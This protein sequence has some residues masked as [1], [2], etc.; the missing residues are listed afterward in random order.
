MS[1][2][3]NG[4]IAAVFVEMADLTHIVGGDEHRIR[5]FRRAARV[6]E[7]LPQDVETAIKYGTFEK[8]AGIG[9]GTVRRCKQI[10]KSG[11]CD[12][13]RELR[14]ILPA[15]LRDLLEV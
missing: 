6:I 3:E 8:T 10:L 4:E 15:G 5:S 14:R 1:N 2:L 13:L 11:S 7:N 12:D 9:P